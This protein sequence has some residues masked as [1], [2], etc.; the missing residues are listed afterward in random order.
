MYN[1]LHLFAILLTITFLNV[2]SVPPTNTCDDIGH[3]G[4][5]CTTLRNGFYTMFDF[6]HTWNTSCCK[7]CSKLESRGEKNN[8]SIVCFVVHHC[9]QPLHVARDVNLALCLQLCLVPYI[10]KIESS[11]VTWFV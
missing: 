8:L 3:A 9:I 10:V 2:A 6:C 4:F 7:T 1:C 5:S 11:G